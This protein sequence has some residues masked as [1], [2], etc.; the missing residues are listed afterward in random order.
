MDN[1]KQVKKEFEQAHYDKIDEMKGQINNWKSHKGDTPRIKEFK[2]KI[3][4]KEEKI[5]ELKVQLKHVKKIS[6]TKFKK[7]YLQK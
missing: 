6:L 4:K 3:E 7:E 1:T 5:K 2:I